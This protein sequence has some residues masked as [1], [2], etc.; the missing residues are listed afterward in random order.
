MQIIIKKKLRILTQKC[1]YQIYIN[2]NQLPKKWQI[3]CRMI[4]ENV[5]FAPCYIHLDF[6]SVGLFLRF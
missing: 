6:I 5:N 3:F 2:G 1:I 4:V